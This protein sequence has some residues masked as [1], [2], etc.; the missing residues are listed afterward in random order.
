MA[1]YLPKGFQFCSKDDLN[2]YKAFAKLS[3]RMNKN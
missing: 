2:W 3:A 1:E